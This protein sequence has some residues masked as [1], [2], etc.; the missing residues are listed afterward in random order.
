VRG[1]RRSYRSLGAAAIFRA[2]NLPEQGKIVPRRGGALRAAI[3]RALVRLAGWSIDPEIPDLPKFVVIAAPHSSNWDFI[4]G[5][6]LVFAL[7][8]DI[9]FIGKA[10]LFRGPLGP[11][12][13]WLGGLPVDRSQPQGVVE[14][15]IALFGAHDQLIV[16]LAPEG[17]RKPVTKWKSGFYRIALGAGVPIVPGYWDNRRRVVGMGPPFHPTGDAEADIAQLR[18]FYASMPRRDQVIGTT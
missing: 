12:M 15:T 7:R 10:E 3:G 18:A 2:M 17:T 16:A 8:L 11:I 14:Q 4:L 5:I 9:H 1:I 13:R 6:G